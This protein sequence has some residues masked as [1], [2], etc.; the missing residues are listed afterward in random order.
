MALVVKNLENAFKKV[1]SDMKEAGENAT[2]KDFSEGISKAVKD[3]IDAGS[4]TTVDKGTVSSGVFVGSGTG[5]T[6]SKDSLMNGVVLPATAT[7]KEMT[8]GGDNVLATAIFNGL[9]ALHQASEVSTDITGTTTSP[10]GSSVPPTSGKGKGTGLTCIDSG[11]VDSVNQIFSNMNSRR[12]EEGFD[13]DSYLAEQLAL[14]TN[15]YIATG[16]VTTSGQGVLKGV[17][18]N[19]KIA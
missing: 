19:G 13:G 9:K 4:V 17:T 10:Q 8:S 15:S 12:D 3:F 7:M 6:T 11:F 5:S 18:G 1:F 14:V 16:T 2:D